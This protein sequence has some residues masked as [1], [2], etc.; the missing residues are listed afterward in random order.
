[1]FFYIM[2]VAVYLREAVPQNVPDI[3]AAREEVKNKTLKVLK[4]MAEKEGET[5]NIL[6]LVLR[7]CPRD[8]IATHRLP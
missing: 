4:V 3:L 1:M 8:T 2:G 5:G 7:Y 6:V